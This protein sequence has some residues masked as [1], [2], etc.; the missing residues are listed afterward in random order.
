MSFI[1]TSFA[2]LSTLIG[3]LI[4]YLKRKDEVII[5][6]LSFAASIMFFM[7]LFDLIPESFNLLNTTLIPLILHIMISINI[8][9]IISIF[10]S[11][12]IN[13]KEKIYRVGIITMIGI[14]IH[15]IPEGI[16]T[17]ITCLNNI[18][19]GTKLAISIALHNIPEGISISIPIYYSTKSKFKAFLYTFIS[20]LSELFGAILAHI[21]LIKI[22]NNFILGILFS[23]IAGIMFHISLK[24][25][26]PL[27]LS[28]NKI[29]Y[30]IISLLLGFLTII[31]TKIVIG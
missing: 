25:L 11:K 19:L 12:I 3:Y 4:I 28:Y 20:G 9:I 5:S 22:I 21:F 30:T 10:I 1:V 26:L 31:I 18:K 24:E 2:G 15:N 8:G 7:S 23:I 27:S 6:S 14:I 17:Y 29:K 16:I 13:K